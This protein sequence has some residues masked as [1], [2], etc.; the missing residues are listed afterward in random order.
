MLLKVSKLIS[1]G[2]VI[3]VHPGD[4]W[5]GSDAWKF[6]NGVLCFTEVMTNLVEWIGEDDSVDGEEDI[7]S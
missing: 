5:Y 7:A 2:T 1:D 4:Q 3:R 6:G